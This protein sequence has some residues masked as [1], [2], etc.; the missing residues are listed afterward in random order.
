MTLTRYRLM[1]ETI[2]LSQAE[3]A[4]RVH[5][6]V[7]IDSISKWERG[8][9]PAPAGVI[10]E[11]QDL[12]ERLDRATQDL[13]DAIDNAGHARAG[14]VRVGI[15][16]T[17]EDAYRFGF[18][19]HQAMMRTIGGAVSRLAPATAVQFVLIGDGDAVTIELP[20]AAMAR[21]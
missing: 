17:P 3:A 19:S 16:E 20:S 18:P 7:A 11:L 14:P 9:N 15:P 21:Q 13:A 1:R 8:R 12:R 2:G 6:G 10:R 4:E 5:G